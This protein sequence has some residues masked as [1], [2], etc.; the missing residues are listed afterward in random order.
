MDSNLTAVIRYIFIFNK[1]TSY[2]ISC[3]EISTTNTWKGN[4]T[5]SVVIISW[6]WIINNAFANAFGTACIQPCFALSHTSLECAAR[7]HPQPTHHRFVSFVKHLERIS[8]CFW[9]ASYIHEF[10]SHYWVGVRT[11]P[12][13]HLVICLN[14]RTFTLCLQWVKP[15]SGREYIPKMDLAIASS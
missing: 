15:M 5:I 8:W 9:R 2:K 6:P 14:I 4:M 11:L 7:N 3:Q 10:P 12:F 13:L 1:S